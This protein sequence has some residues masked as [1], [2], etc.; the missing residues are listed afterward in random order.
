MA[1]MLILKAIAGD[2]RGHEFTFRSPASCVV[3][4]SRSCMLRLPGDGT[5]SRQHCVIEL[6][7]EGAWIQD[8]GSLNGTHING[9]KIGQREPA[10][11]NDA[12]MVQPARQS[13][14]NGDQ[15]PGWV[16]FLRRPKATETL[17]GNIVFDVPPKHY[18]VHLS[19]E[20]DQRHELVDIP[21]NF[22]SESPEIPQAAQ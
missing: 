4:R 3:G 22:E 13:L 2:L 6:E 1:T 19:D 15:V 9:S 16:G 12:T 18:R 8:L 11:T 17:Q 20:N 7:S 5:V 14:S 10:P 21:L